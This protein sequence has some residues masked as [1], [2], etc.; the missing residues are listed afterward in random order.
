GLPCPARA[1]EG[2]HGAITSSVLPAILKNTFGL[3]N[4]LA[5]RVAAVVGGHHGVF[6]RSD[7]VRRLALS[8]VGTRGW[9]DARVELAKALANV[10]DVPSQAPL[11]VLS[12]T[13]AMTLAGLVSVAD[14][15][16]SN[17]TYFPYELPV[18]LSLYSDA[19]KKRARDAIDKLAWTGSLPPEAQSFAALFPTL[20]PRPVQRAAEALAG[21]LNGPS[22]VI[23]E[24]PTGEGKTEA[25]IYLADNAGMV[26][27]ERGCY[28]ALPTQATSNQMFGRVR[29][30]LSHRYRGDTVQLQLL[31]GHAALSAE[32]D[33]LKR[34]VFKIFEPRGIWDESYRGQDSPNVVA[35]EWFTHRKRGLLAPFGVGTIDQALLAILQTKHV[36][37][38]LFG[39]AHKPVILDEVHAYDTYMSTLLERL[40]EWLAALGSCVVLL[41]ATLPR[42]RRERLVNAYAKGLGRS[43]LALLGAAYPRVSWVSKTAQGATHVETSEQSTKKVQLE[44]VDGDLSK[45]AGGAFELG[46]RLKTALEHGGCAAVICNTVDRAQQMY[47]A[48]KPYFSGQADDGL[49]EL[50]LLHARFIFQEREEREKRS[51][52]RFGK[53]GGK[54][55]LPDGSTGE[56]RRPKKAVLVATQVIEQSL[57]LDFDLMVTDLAPADLVL[58]RAGRLHRHER[59]RPAGLDTPRL[60]VCRPQEKDGVPKFDSGK[61]AIYDA[62][63]LLRSWLVLKVLGV[64]HVPGDVEEIVEAVY[65]DGPCPEGLP[66]AVRDVWKDTG[67]KLAEKRA[68][69]EALASQFRILPPD[70]SDDILEDFNRE[71]EEDDPTV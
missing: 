66:A 19:A 63:V 70:H 42:A 38:R 52:V 41:S 61:K 16:G 69:H 36:F 68:K 23:I 1:P 18:D 35:A 21:N 51:E 50:D 57:D 56:V 62:H 31:H 24:A 12:N 30:F 3:S 45:I 5:S 55:H 53:L 20:E 14:W 17:E 13:V 54:V 43:E 37:V 64:I 33:V 46:T 40:L 26:H 59:P 8:E 15:I 58:Q 47:R 9:A 39:L 11:G 22:M 44:W 4:E 28:F 34:N 60:W 25:A 67:Q 2:H 10:I 6:P 65:D 29:D 71:L 27:G 32:F 48:L 7:E 49:P